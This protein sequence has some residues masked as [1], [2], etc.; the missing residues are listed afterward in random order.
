MTEPN[1]T[2][3]CRWLCWGLVIAGLAAVAGLSRLISVAIDKVASGHGLDTYRT[4]LARRV[5]LRWLTR[6]LWR[7]R[8]GTHCRQR[9]VAL[10]LVAVALT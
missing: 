7:N 10:R 3:K 9:N 5:Q 4:S 6:T 8:C 2:R 1:E